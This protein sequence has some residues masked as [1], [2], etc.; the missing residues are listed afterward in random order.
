MNIRKLA[1]RDDL[2]IRQVVLD[3][4]QKRDQIVH[5][6]RA[7]NQQIP[8]HLKRKT[9]DYDILTDNP[10]KSAR[11]LVKTLRRRLGNKFKVVK[12]RNKGTFKVKREDKTVADYT[13]MRGKVKSKRILGIKYKDL[14]TIKRGTQKL[15]KK[16]GAE[17]RRGK[18]FDTLR[19]IKKVERMGRIFDRL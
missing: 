10:R 11:E 4:A 3:M 17:F 14:G 5:G 9:K 8:T 6:T 18:D 2:V 15:V 13:Q 1:G 16:K 7:L 19:R 12:G